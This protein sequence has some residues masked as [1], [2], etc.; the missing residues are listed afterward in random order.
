M[1][2]E[3][4]AD[5][6]DLQEEA[7]EKFKTV[8]KEKKK[9][10]IT[11]DD[12]KSD[13]EDYTM[14]D[15]SIPEVEEEIK[16]E[17][18]EETEEVEEETEE[19]EETEEKVD[20]SAVNDVIT[21]VG[22]DTILKIK[23]QEYRVGDLPKD[24]VAS[25]L[26]KG[27]RFY[28]RMEELAAKEKD[29]TKKE[30]I[31]N[32]GAETVQ[33]L[34][35]NQQGDASVETI[36]TPSELQADEMDSDEVKALKKISSDLYKKVN[37]LEKNYEQTSYQSEWNRLEGEI[38]SLTPDYPLASKEEVIA[39][40]ANYPN[41]TV[42]EIMEKSHNYYASDEYFDKVL[43]ARP[44]KARELSEKAESN[45]LAR[46]QKTTGKKVARKKSA[47]TATGKVSD[48]KPKR[49]RTFEEARIAT[50]KFLQGAA[51]GED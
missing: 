32:R 35:A 24:E 45:Y 47:S 9:E 16:E 31:L 40:K 43:A 27:L 39:I 51:E 7:K 41:A 20:E 6:E 38:N 46:K 33:R 5:Y 22:E 44:E 29:L 14:D 2:D 34:M 30:E 17:A 8:D 19:V 48:S 25:Y 36:S 12:L 28:Q 18:E 49:P 42:R 21:A 50:Q 4:D 11:F 13:D 10:D 26:Q 37:K 1:V 15:D 23:G 3:L